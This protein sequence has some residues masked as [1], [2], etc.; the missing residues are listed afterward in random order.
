MQGAYKEE[1]G[2]GSGPAAT[3]NRKTFLVH[4]EAAGLFLWSP[5]GYSE[6]VCVEEV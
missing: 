2:G 5:S 6:V 3:G 4:N 1:G